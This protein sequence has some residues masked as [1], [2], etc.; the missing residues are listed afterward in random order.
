MNDGNLETAG[1]HVTLVL[2][3]V[4]DRTS[5]KARPSATLPAPAPAKLACR[6][7]K[8]DHPAF[9]R[10]GDTA[11]L[12]PVAH[13]FFADERPSVG[14]A[15]RGG[16]HRTVCCADALAWL[17][18]R[19][20]PRRCHVVCSPPDIGE[21]KPI[22]SPTTRR[23][24]STRCGAV[25]AALEPSAVALF[26]VTDG[27]R[28][29]PDETYLDKSH[30]C[31]RGAEAAGAACLFHR[32]VLGG[33]AGVARAGSTRPSY[34]HL[35]AFSVALRPPRDA[36]VWSD[37]VPT[38]GHMAY[39]GATGNARAPRRLRL[40]WARTRCAAA[41]GGG[42]DGGDGGGDGE[43]GEPLPPRLPEAEDDAPALVLDPFCGKGSILAAANAAGLD[44]YGIDSNPM[45]CSISIE[46]RLKGDD[47]SGGGPRG[48]RGGTVR[49]RRPVAPLRAS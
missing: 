22:S 6:A 20:L 27:R 24:L 14:A 47:G 37:V 5:R 38:R 31:H 26:Y 45:R 15:L 10:G 29:G 30:L 34:A 8:A 35:L 41:A 39:M 9:P 43:E 49:L 44:A 11:K 40:C 48:V 25:L 28:S 2:F 3:M 42:G 32:I 16:V 18:D 13:A 23:G 46:H 21:L 17:R 19:R 33:P 7:R 12:Q 1:H 36:L 4:L